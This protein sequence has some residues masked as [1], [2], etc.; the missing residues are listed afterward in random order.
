MKTAQAII[1]DIDCLI[2]EPDVTDA[3]TETIVCL[4]GIGGDDASFEPQL[5]LADQYRVIAWNMPGYKKSAT[6]SPLTFEVIAEKLHRFIIA[7]DAG[8][9]HLMGQS[10]GGMIAQETYHRYPDSIKSLTLV[11]TTA[12]F[13][14][15]DESFKNAFLKARLKPLDSGM[16][17]Q[18]MADAAM[19]AI[20]GKNT[21]RHIIEAAIN[22][23]SSLN[24]DVY[25]DVLRCLVTFNRRAE[26]SKIKCPVC[27]VSGSEDTNAPAVTM[28]K[29]G[30]G[31]SHAHYHEIA[32]AGHLVNLEKG[33]EFNI[34]VRSFLSSQGKKHL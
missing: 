12:A 33:A 18:Q 1:A 13:G 3:G 11:A 16:N 31:L 19:P 27:L 17:M 34:I 24:E 22:S 5:P 14:G 28:Q 4:H 30:N 2:S 7:L 10:I 9:V 25:R 32:G 21:E 6:V 23:M 29:M 26:W 20:V 8:S 15:R